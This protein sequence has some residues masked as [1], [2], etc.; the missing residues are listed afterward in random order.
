VR[1]A[2]LRRQTS[3]S[4]AGDLFGSAQIGEALIQYC[5]RQIQGRSQSVG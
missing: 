5:G 3:G 2:K 4:M 1:I